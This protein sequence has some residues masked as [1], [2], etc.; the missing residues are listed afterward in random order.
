MLSVSFRSSPSTMIRKTGSVPLYRTRILP[1]RP[2]FFSNSA[3]AFWNRGNFSRGTR[4]LS[5]RLT[6]ICGRGTILFPSSASRFPDSTITASTWSAAR[7]P[8]PVVAGAGDVVRP[9]R[10]PAT[11]DPHGAPV[12]LHLRGHQFRIE[13]AALVVD[14]Q[15]V[16]GDAHG[17]DVGAEFL[18]HLRGDP[19]R[20][21]V[22]AIDHNSHP[23]QG[24]MPGKGV[25]EI[26]DVPARGVVDPVRPADLRGGGAELPPPVPQP[27]Q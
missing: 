21:P 23:L 18:E 4:C 25:L 11:R 2:S 1:L 27:E 3:F 10:V 8:S 9:A 16:R 15:P 6:R 22:G 19:V 20:R 7:T 17:N 26:D 24:Q 14:V 5:F 12:L 13:G